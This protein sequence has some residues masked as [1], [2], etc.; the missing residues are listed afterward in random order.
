VGDREKS[1]NPTD[2]HN[3]DA[4]TGKSP[5][6]DVITGVDVGP[7]GELAPLSSKEPPDIEKVVRSWIWAWLVNKL[8][9]KY[10]I[11][12]LIVGF[13][14]WR[15]WPY[16]P[17]LS[18][19]ISEHLPLPKAD[20]SVFTVA[21]VPLDNDDGQIEH[22]IV[23]DLKEIEEIK[24]QPFNRPPISD[25]DVHAGNELARKYLKQSN[26]QVI[27]WGTVLVGDKKVPKLYWTA[28]GAK[29]T[30]ESGHYPFQDDG[31]L[32]LAFKNDLNDL[33]GLLVVTQGTAFYGQQGH[34]VADRLVPFV[35]RVERLL[36]GDSRNGWSVEDVAKIRFILA[37][38]Q[39]TLGEQ[40]G[41][42]HPL[43]DA[44]ENYQLVLQ[45]ET[46]AS[47]PLEWA[48]TE[49]NL[50]LALEGLGEL[51]VGT[52]HLRQAVT[53]Y[54]CAL[55]E[56]TR[57][58][59]PL[60]W[61]EIENNRGV[62]LRALGEREAGS[63]DLQEA[64]V[65]CHLALLE[66]TRERVPFEWAMTQ[67]NL[68]AVFTDLGERESNSDDLL[69]AIY[70][71]QRAL[72]EYTRQR[73]PLEWAATENNLGF[74]LGELGKLK[75]DERQKVASTINDSSGIDD[76]RQA[77]IAYQSA[78]LEYTRVR[79]PLEWA[80]TENNLS[81]ALRVLGEH[82]P[83]ITDLQQAAAACRLALLERT[84][85]RAPLEWA[86]TES[87]FG[88]ALRDLGERDKDSKQLCDAL[89]AHTNA[90]QILHV[91]VPHYA[92][93]TADGIEK[94]LIVI[95]E[96]HW[97]VTHVACVTDQAQTLKEIG[98]STK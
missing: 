18:N 54:Q 68:G 10:S 64:A 38:A 48:A 92:Q 83:G 26:A 60:E 79:V 27:I 82:E 21:I 87:N 5:H 81:V 94:D 74:A 44:I 42:D 11:V 53:A 24:V 85:T 19:V 35:E 15:T 37:N 72:L 86:V 76:L 93:I 67:N 6:V 96:Q 71:Y 95:N 34:F 9:I 46:R 47:V 84:R 40:N 14:L 13:V 16:I 17:A 2:S 90:W 1:H 8:G 78:L 55:L 7:S 33:L 51:E 50:G 20:P 49:N 70:A 3:T 63:D 43:L 88:S 61:A 89:V 31:S 25:Q 65:A 97:P 98:I 28:K 75:L 4:P 29:P 39:T 45:Q 69:Q 62:A 36:E 22:D 30:K 52:D 32:P 66:R 91:A 56:Y 77:V 80:A 41:Q 59:D 58:R 12:L 73:D 57:E 23:E